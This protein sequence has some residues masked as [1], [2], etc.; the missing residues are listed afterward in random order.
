MNTMTNF[1]YRVAQNKA[2]EAMNL[3]ETMT[4]RDLMNF[5][6][7]AMVAIAKDC[8]NKEPKD[9]TKDEAY[10]VSFLYREL[11]DEAVARIMNKINK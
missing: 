2:Y 7:E 6:Y 5:Q 9:L 3:K 4:M 10:A 8:Y 1:Q 11:S